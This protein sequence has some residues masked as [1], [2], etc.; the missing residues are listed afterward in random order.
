M[1][2]VIPFVLVGYGAFALWNARR[3]TDQPGQL[4]RAGLTCLAVGVLSMPLAWWSG[5]PELS[6]VAGGALLVVA[7]RSARSTATTTTS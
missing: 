1:L 4:R 2:L 5:I 6:V 7:R 3:P